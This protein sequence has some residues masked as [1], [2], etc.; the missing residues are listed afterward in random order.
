VG[1]QRAIIIGLCFVSG[2]NHQS[3]YVIVMDSDGEDKP[4]D[5]PRLIKACKEQQKEKIIFARRDKRSEGMKFKVSYYFYKALFYALTSK[6]I[7]FGNFSCIPVSFLP[8]IIH[9]A[10]FWNH[11]SA[12]V[13]K[14]K[15][16]Y[17]SCSTN[18]GKRY[19]GKSKMNFTNLV[20]HG[21]SALSLYL[22]VIIVRFLKLSLAALSIVLA[23]LLVIL[24][25][26]YFTE[27]A[28]PGWASVVFAITINILVTISLFT[29]IVILLHLSNRSQKPSHPINFYKPLILSVNEHK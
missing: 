5:I 8:K 16:P 15:M 10:D 23:L 28:I 24:Y 20:I 2:M 4:S 11:Y 12:S 6:N 17:E 26:K 3:D 21:L 13:I 9:N 14:S 27:L 29:F 7:K 19:T 25:V 1:H 18:R 22:D